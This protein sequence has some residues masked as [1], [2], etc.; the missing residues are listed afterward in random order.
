MAAYLHA[1]SINR[2]QLLQGASL[3]GL[4]LLA[5]CGRWPG[6]G[7]A[8][9]PAAGGMTLR[10]IGVLGDVPAA[11]W[12]A[13][14]EGL[15]ELGWV[16]GQ[17]LAV[18]YRWA[19][20][21]SERQRAL[22]AELVGLNVECIAAGTRA[23]AA[24]AKQVT[25]TVPIVAILAT[26]EALENALVD[27][28]ARPGGNITGMAGIS[29]ADLEGK[30]L[31]LL[32]ETVPRAARVALLGREAQAGIELR[33]Q[34]LQSAAATLGMQVQ[35]FSVEHP[36]ALADAF[37]AMSAAG[38]D[39]LKIVANVLFDPVWPEIADLAARHR[40]PAIAERI[41]FPRVGGL[42]AYGV[43][44]LDSYRRAATYVDKLL[45]GARPGDLPMERPMRF[46]FGV[47]LK[48]ARELGLTLP[49]EIMLQVTEVVQ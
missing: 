40:L 35:F 2:R 12:D 16:E 38:A 47:N 48:T 25:A 7:Q 4:G 34:A 32:K 6:Q 39:A 26:G 8:Q 11:R 22:T 14:R 20:G 43:N 17:N 28:I 9:Q 27:N 45:K 33:L 49:P 31:Q 18:E 5:G 46:D 42:M 3:T 1:V 15:R 29:G 19:E 30:Q 36:R 23:A 44:L 24:A 41:E 10:R 37:S 21:N 13:F